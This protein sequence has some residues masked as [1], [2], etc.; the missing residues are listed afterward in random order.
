[1]DAVTVDDDGGGGWSNG[2]CCCRDDDDEEEIGES[3]SGLKENLGSSVV[4][5]GSSAGPE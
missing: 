1:M 3:G 4:G 2:C 5:C